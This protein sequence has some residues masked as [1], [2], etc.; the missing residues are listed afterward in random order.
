MI[1]LLCVEGRCVRFGMWA[2]GMGCFVRGDVGLCADKIISR[3]E[4]GTEKRRG[5]ERKKRGRV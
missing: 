5:E 1:L 3:K 2:F 4:E